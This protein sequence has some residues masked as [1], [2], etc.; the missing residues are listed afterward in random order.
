MKD[1]STTLTWRQ[2]EAGKAYKRRIGLYE[3]IKRN[4]RYYRGDQWYGASVPDLPK[5]VFNVVRRI[6]DYLVC[7]VVSGNIS[8]AYTDEDLPFIESAAV[9]EALVRGTELLTRHA[10]YRWEKEK[11]DNLMYRLL[12]DA[13]LSGDGV[14]YCSWD[15]SVRTGQ[16]YSGDIVTQ[17]LDNTELFVADVNKTDLQS[18]EYIILSGRDSVAALC[19]EAKL[20]G[21]SEHDIKKILPDSAD[22]CG[23]GD[24]SELELED[25]ASAKATYLIKLWRENGSV[26]CEKSTRSAVIRRVNTGLRL[27]PVAYF[28]WYPTKNSFHGTSPVTGMIPNQRFINRAY[29]MV[30]KHMTDTAFSKV[31]YD[32]SKIPEWSNE[33]GEA[34][35]AVGGGNIADAVSVVGVG[36]MQNGYL[37]LI[38]NAIANTKELSGATDTAL[39]EKDPTNTSAILA[40]QE[41]ARI[42]LMQVRAAFCTCLENLAAIW[43]D[44]I[45]NYY[46]EGRFIT[47]EDEGELV[48][49]QFDYSRLR[50]SLVSAH[51]EV[52]NVDRASPITTQTVLDRLLAEKCISAESYISLLPSGLIQN[53]DRLLDELRRYE[54]RSVTAD[55]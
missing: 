40:M 48:A 12:L 19:R 17:V 27:Y 7:T 53:R 42:P 29:A 9:R 41:A 31:I 51:V 45:F 18:Q 23:S 8:I 55:A 38:E 21:A 25:T 32:K 50:D 49:E 16:L 22:D 2:Y 26:I 10:A 3:N 35:A 36:S 43:A 28:N 14:L 46:P 52:G 24:L 33:V 1:N 5:P 15:P 34:I 4:E 13:A 54:E 37:E 20:Y 6:V 30:M 39:G 47:F 44:M 11:L